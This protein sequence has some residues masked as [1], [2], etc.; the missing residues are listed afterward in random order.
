M[1]TFGQ[2]TSHNY[3]SPFWRVKICNT[4]KS[5]GLTDFNMRYH[6]LITLITE[7]LVQALA[8][9][10][11]AKTFGEYSDALSSIQEEADTRMVL[12]ACEAKAKGYK[13]T[14]VISSNTDVLVLLIAFYPQ[15]SAEVWMKAGTSATQRY[16]AVHKIEVSD[17]VRCGILA[18]HAITEC[19]SISQFCG[20]S[21]KMAWK[22]FC[23]VPH[24]LAE[25]GGTHSPTAQQQKNLCAGCTTP[26]ETQTTFRHLDVPS[27]GK[28]QGSSKTY[29]RRARHFV[30]TS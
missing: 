24:L 21:K 7:A 5:A 4:D 11:E 3:C 8:K 14:V 16:I 17:D 2:P 19:D 1:E 15:L 28:A 6:R 13:R 18:F 30:I 9:P 10:K 23:E 29:L 12:H 22:I 25:L 26:L 27:S 20:K